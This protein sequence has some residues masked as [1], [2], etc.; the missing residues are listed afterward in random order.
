MNPNE[1]HFRPAKTF[2]LTG[3]GFT[4]PFG[5]FLADEMWAVILNQPEIR[6]YRELRELMLE[7]LGYETLYYEVLA[8][9]DYTR[10]AKNAFTT[11]IQNAYHRM[12]ESICG[13]NELRDLARASQVCTTIIE[14][15]AGKEKEHEK[16]LIFTL[17]QDLFVERFYS[18]ENLLMRIPG[19]HNPR[20]FNGQLGSRLAEND[21]V[22][23]PD[24][25]MV[26]EEKARCW[27]KS[28]ERL[29][30]L[31]LHGS[32]GWRARDGDEIMV[33]GH[34]KMKLIER[35]P[36]LRWYFS[37][38]EEVL[39][40]E[41]QNLVAIG[42]G[43]GDEH[44]NEVIA[45]AILKHRL[46]LYVVSTKLP[47]DFRGMLCP[48]HGLGQWPKPR[49]EDLWKGLFGYYQASVTDFYDDNGGLTPIGN[50]FF[51]D[52]GLN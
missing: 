43:F 37:L 23:L 41:E 3:A 39:R 4:K 9:N 42:Y 25:R 19:L 30:Y 50:A 49:G 17:N 8:S 12:H 18:A 36:L 2:L 10:D 40:D 52:L 6:Q 20:W 28:A 51:R 14:R 11:A 38:F 7:K 34:A 13:K 32:Y 22:Q 47:K 5:G 1:R 45:D 44:I 48:V 31:K 16:G 33:I 27:A 26:E 24:E 21:R 15:F 29:V 35:E 46:R